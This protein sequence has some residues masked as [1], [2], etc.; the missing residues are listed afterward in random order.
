MKTVLQKII[1]IIA[2]LLS[3]SVY[4]QDYGYFVTF[5]DKSG[6]PFSVDKPEEFLSI[7]AVERREKQDIPVTERDLPVS[8]VYTDSLKNLG[9]TVKHTTKWFNGCIVFTSNT[10][11]MDTLEEYDFVS[12]VELTYIPDI[13][14]SAKL[15]KTSFANKST[16]TEVYG[17]A[18]DQINTVNGI[19]LHDK[20]YMGDGMVIAIIDA[21]F[22]G[23]DNLPAFTHLWDDNRILGTKDFVNPASDIFREHTHGMNVLSIIGGKMD[24]TY[25]GTAP[26]ASFYLLRTEDV[27][28]EYPVEADYWICAAEFADS[29]GV[30]VINTS[31]GYYTF[32]D[33]AM[34]YSYSQLD[35]NSIRI[36]KA[37]SIAASTGMIVVISAGNE[38]ASSWHYISAPADAENILAVGAMTSDSVKATFSSF[39]PTADGRIKPDVTAMG[40]SV[41][42]Q[43][44]SGGI[45]TGSGT[46][47]SA[48]VITG[49][50]ACLWQSLDNL[51]SDEIIKLIIESSNNFENPDNN[52]GYGIPDFKTAHAT[53]VSEGVELQDLWVVFPNPFRDKLIISNTIG[54]SEND[55]EISLFDITGILKFRE[56]ISGDEPKNYVDIPS[57]LSDG[58]YI[59]QVKDGAKTASYKIMK[60]DF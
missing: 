59:L 15:E 5:V 8:P 16:S 19:P 18:F 7:R 35:G 51:S 58:M 60:E 12:F 25:L 42:V 28:S 31:L 4:A 40:V 13:S 49:L 36:S 48:P 52:M 32:D 11:L 56:V 30:D 21:G 1:F 10:A 24:G 34:S 22:Y 46:S 29:A 33:D 50:S 54:E 43:N 9:L 45:S 57:Y 53:T 6:T 17:S 37:A 41:A 44:T 55:L 26:D 2:G 3:V 39:G 27:N 47:F 20:G 14:G 38:G 23:V